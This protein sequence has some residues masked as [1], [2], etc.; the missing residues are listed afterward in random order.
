M[1]HEFVAVIEMRLCVQVCVDVTGVE[2]VMST[3]HVCT[4]WY[5]ATH[6][7]YFANLPQLVLMIFIVETVHKRYSCTHQVHIA[8]Q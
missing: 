7:G 1:G 2:T 4:T 6:C 5:I 3:L 8:A